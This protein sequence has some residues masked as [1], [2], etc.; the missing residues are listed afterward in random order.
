MTRCTAGST[1]FPTTHAP[2]T[3]RIVEMGLLTGRGTLDPRYF[4]HATPVIEGDMTAL[5]EIRRPYEGEEEPLWDSELE[6]WIYPND[7]SPVW[8][9]MAR[10]Q[11]NKDWRARNREWA[12]RKSTRLNSSHVKIS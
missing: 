12:D 9:G 5:I 6:E 3:G 8:K 7:L 11:P 2:S 10:I 1:L 4:R